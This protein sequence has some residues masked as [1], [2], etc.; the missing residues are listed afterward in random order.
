MRFPFKGPWCFQC[1][2]E[3]TLKWI[4]LIFEW[5]ISL[6]QSVIYLGCPCLLV[7]TEATEF[8]WNVTLTWAGRSFQW[9]KSCPTADLIPALSLS[10]G[11][12]EQ[13]LERFR[14]NQETLICALR[15]PHFLEQTHVQAHKQ[16]VVNVRLQRPGHLSFYSTCLN[17]H[18]HRPLS[19][20]QA[21]NYQCVWEKITAH[22]FSF[23]V[24]FFAKTKP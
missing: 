7:S 24:L 3:H 23:S 21:A 18:L 17:N 14:L 19:L 20:Q 1:G 10:F 4:D 12:D 15:E 16:S 11:R 8:S 9:G 22:T 13:R 2:P 5:N 6:N